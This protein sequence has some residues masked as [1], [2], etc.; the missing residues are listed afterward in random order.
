MAVRIEKGE[1]CGT[2]T[3]TPL[4]DVLFMLLIFF[5]VAS[6]FA[7]EEKEIKVS[8]PEAAEAQPMIAKPSELT[9]NIT[10]EG[11]FFAEGQVVDA[12]ALDQIIQQAWNRN[13]GRTEVKIRADKTSE[14]QYPVLVMGICN[15][16]GVTYSFAVAD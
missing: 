1:A 12:E 4:I 14:T 5:M 13:P 10:A 3:L 15:R 16:Y 6:E 7:K 11:E 8:L 9:V 2:L